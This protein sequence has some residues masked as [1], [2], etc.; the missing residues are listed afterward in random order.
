MTLTESTEA[1]TGETNSASTN[2]STEELITTL[3]SANGPPTSG[4][5]QEQFTN[6]DRNSL[7]GRLLPPAEF[8][9]SPSSLSVSPSTG[10]EAGTTAIALP[11]TGDDTF[12]DRTLSL[13]TPPR[14]VIVAGCV[15]RSIGLRAGHQGRHRGQRVPNRRDRGT[16]RVAQRRHIQHRRRSQTLAGHRRLGQRPPWPGQRQ[17]PDHLVRQSR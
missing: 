12:R 15:P 2:F 16:A 6:S 11:A 7:E 4:V 17:R 8:H 5:D 14:P 1:V 10:T 13:G 9:L 3:R